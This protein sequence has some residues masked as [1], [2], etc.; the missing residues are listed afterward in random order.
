MSNVTY[1]TA[2]EILIKAKSAVG[3]TLGV[4]DV[5]QRLEEGKGGVGHV[6]EESL[7][8]YKINSSSRPDFPEAGVELKVTPFIKKKNGYTA[9]ERLVLNIINYEKE[10]KKQ[11][12]ES[13]FWQKNNT[14]LIMFYE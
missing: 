13:S 5:N 14:L 6:I 12:E 10:Y 11:F 1:K 3:K 7:F 2:E 4:I 8:E 9:K